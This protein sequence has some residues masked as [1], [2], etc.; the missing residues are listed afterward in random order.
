M[1]CKAESKAFCG[2]IMVDVKASRRLPPT[3][4][5]VN[6]H[7]V[8]TRSCPCPRFNNPYYDNRPP[9]A[10]DIIKPVFRV[11]SLIFFGY[12]LALSDLSSV[13]Q[14]DL[15]RVRQPGLLVAHT[16]MSCTGGL[17]T[18]PGQTNLLRVCL[19]WRY[20]P[21]RVSLLPKGTSI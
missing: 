11:V 10:P 15:A 16:R 12:S 18:L 8:F 4:P 14:S 13:G 21:G 6:Q 5:T 2:I 20:L 9:C 17:T 1:I 3:T 7:L 19:C